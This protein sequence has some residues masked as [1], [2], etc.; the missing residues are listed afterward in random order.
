[1]Y[2]VII[3]G[4]G[5]SGITAAKK[6]AE[7]GLKTLIIEKCRLPRDKVCSGMIMGPVAHALIQH[8]FGPLPETVLTKPSQLE[9]YFFHVPGIGSEKLDHFTLLTWRR[10]LDFWMLEKA[11]ACGVELWQGVSAIDIEQ[12]A[13]GHSITIRT[14]K[15]RKDLKTKFVIGADGGNSTIRG[16]LFPE[17]K[18]KYA[19]VYQEHYSGELNLNRD[20][21]HWFYPLEYS[22]A[23]FTA[24]QKDGLI[25][26]DVGGKPGQ[27]K[28]LMASAKKYLAENHGLAVKQEP[29]WRGGC[30]QPALYRELTSH[31]FMPACRN[32]LLVGDAA[33]LSMPVSGEGIGTGMKS[34]LLAASSIRRAGE[35]GESADA[36]YLEGLD[37]IVSVFRDIYPWFRR[38]IGEAKNGGYSMP[39]VLRD[40][41]LAALRPF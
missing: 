15:E 12:Q 10:N 13:Q 29:V 20:Y 21:M 38:I 23:S 22:P 35:T 33:G 24:H 5:P 37:D 28:Q 40:G 8:E 11:Q 34:A 26:V 14:G 41:Y 25:I 16:F 36:I 1:M 32:A 27:A 19:Q 18:V 9:G 17:L 31:T 3:V 30:L 7:Q 2:D 6:C 39:Q 4:A